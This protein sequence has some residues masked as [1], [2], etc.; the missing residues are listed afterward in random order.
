MKSWLQRNAKRID[1]TLALLTTIVITLF[2]LIPLFWVF[3]TS[4][5]PMGSEYLIPIQLWPEEP[6]LNAYRNVID[7]LGFLTPLGNSFLVS[8]STA[9]LCLVVSA[10]AAYAVARLR[11]QFKVQSLVLLQLGAMIPPVVTIAPTFVLLKEIGLLKSLPAMVIPNVFYSVPLATWLLAS[12][13]AE[14]PFELE[15]AAKVDGY[16]PFQIFLRVILPLS[17]PG[18]FAAG[19]FAFI[20]SYGEFM[21]AS[22]VT[23]GIK[24]VQTIPVAIQNFSFAFRQQWTWISAGVVLAILPVITIVL[25]FQRWVIRGLTAGSVKY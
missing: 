14:L 25:I 19:M 6:T 15:D 16:R 3:S 21:L 24:D 23:L 7:E 9:I 18:M 12:Y 5:K 11:F 2:C 17:L 13:F 22:V 4:L 1:R 10:T 20:G 8:L